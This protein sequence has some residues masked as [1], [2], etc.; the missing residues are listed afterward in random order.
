MMK[1]TPGWAELLS[2]SNVIVGMRHAF[3]ESDV[4]GQNPVEQ[5]GS[6]SSARRR[7]ITSTMTALCLKWAEVRTYSDLTWRAKDECRARTAT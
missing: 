5:G 1:D 7:F 2:D 3:R 4:G 6:L